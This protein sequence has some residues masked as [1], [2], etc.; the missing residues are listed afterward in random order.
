MASFLAASFLVGCADSQ[1]GGEV[2]PSNR[3]IILLTNGNSPYWDAFAAGA[4]EAGAKLDVGK[5][6]LQV[7]VD[8]GDF[9]PEVQ[10]DKL[11]QYQGATDIAA[12][13]I[14]VTDP[15]NQA[16]VNELAALSDSGVKLITVDSDIDRNNPKARK[17]RF[18]Y[19]GTDNLAAGKELGKAAKAL[20]P[21]GANYAT[22]VGV[23]SAANAIERIGG[24]AEGAGEGFTSLESMGDEGKTDRA[25]KNVRDAIDRHDDLNMLVGIWSYN[26][27]A[28]VDIVRELGIRD[29]MAV[30]GFDAD[31]PAIAAMAE[32]NLDVML[33][34]DPYQMGYE[35]V[36]L[37]KALLN[38]DQGTVK[39][40]LPNLGQ[41]DGDIV[42]TG[43]KI[44]VPSADSPI[45]AELFEEGTTFL[46]LDEFKEWLAK[47]NLTGS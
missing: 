28:M 8:R 42:E 22:F 33:V 43:L 1:N 6:G 11:R 29:K 30:V 3:R 32:G 17:A 23:K 16:L 4:N 10:L 35:G 27:P 20:K 45:K 13:A 21:E 15:K 44:V 46:T 37:L 47:Y 2:T 14:C 25:K 18:A 38:D 12:V 39:E 41:E 9:S 40:I 7:V 31:P 26:T 24:F 34:Q 5:E 36:R 19:L